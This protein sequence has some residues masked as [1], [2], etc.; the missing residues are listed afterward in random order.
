M[1]ELTY[2]PIDYHQIT[3][4]VRTPLAG[5]VVLFLGTVRELTGAERTLYLDYSAY[6][7]MAEKKLRDIEAE[8]RRRWSVCQVAMVHRLGRCD[9]GTISVAVA[10]SAPHRVEA[11]AA[12][13][14]AMD[15][16]KAEVP[17]WK[18]DHTPDG[19]STWIHP[20]TTG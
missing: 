19:S 10:V 12:A 8:V 14:W 1:I 4:F 5:A 13:Q 11:F 20:E 2:E 16:I 9:A 6:T 17:I 7:P 18:Q 3:E 15:T